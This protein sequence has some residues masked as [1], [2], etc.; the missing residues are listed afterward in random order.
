MLSLTQFPL[1]PGCENYSFLDQAIADFEQGLDSILTDSIETLELDTSLDEPDV[2]PSVSSGLLHSVSTFSDT[3]KVQLAPSNRSHKLWCQARAF[4]SSVSL[5][6]KITTSKLISYFS[7]YSA[8]IGF[9]SSTPSDDITLTPAGRKADQ[10]FRISDWH[11]CSC[12]CHTQ[13]GAA[14]F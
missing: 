2:I 13:H 9:W 3:S 8:S 1:E 7:S 12:L 4:L 11:W 5:V 6:T 10:S 14:H